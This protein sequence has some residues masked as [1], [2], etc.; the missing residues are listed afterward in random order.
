VEAV[1]PHFERV[2]P[3][4]DAVSLG[5]VEPT[6]QSNSNEGNP[7]F[8][9]IGEKYSVRKN[10]FLGLFSQKRRRFLSAVPMN[11]VDIEW[12][13]CFNLYCSELPR[14]YRLFR[15]QFRPPRPASSALTVGL[16]TMSDTRRVQ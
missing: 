12:L 16:E 8:G 10:V 3:F 11:R 4:S 6:A 9:T 5:N 1:D 13:L 14:L 7:K 2:R 15:R